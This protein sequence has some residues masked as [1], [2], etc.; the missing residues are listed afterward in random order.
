MLPGEE[1]HTWMFLTPIC[2]K[3]FKTLS[4]LTAD[5]AL[6]RTLDYSPLEVSSSLRYSVNTARR[7]TQKYTTLSPLNSIYIAS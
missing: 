3:P 1:I 4:G 6:R 7:Q 2:I 5:P